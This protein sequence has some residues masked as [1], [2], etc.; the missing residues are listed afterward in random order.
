MVTKDCEIIGLHDSGKMILCIIL[1]VFEA[2]GKHDSWLM[3]PVTYHPL[4]NNT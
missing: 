3:I 4:P 2:F 1:F